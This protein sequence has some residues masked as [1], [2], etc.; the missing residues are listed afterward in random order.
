MNRRKLMSKTLDAAMAVSFLTFV[1]GCENKPVEVPYKDLGY[2]NE[3]ITLNGKPFTG[4]GLDTAKDG[5][6]RVRW[7]LKDGVPHGVVKEW[8]PNGQLIVETG[9]HMGK[10]H[11]LNRYW[12]PEGQ[13]TKE[14]VYEHGTS[15]SIKEYPAK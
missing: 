4:V 14:Q 6:L 10:R 15:V 11:G 12:T 9:Y 13:L 7:E 1:P 5:K 2:E 3:K 8:A